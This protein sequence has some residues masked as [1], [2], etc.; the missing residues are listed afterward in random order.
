MYNVYRLP[1]SITVEYIFV[2]TKY[3]QGVVYCHFTVAKTLRLH[4]DLN[5]PCIVLHYIVKYD[6]AT[7]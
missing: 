4:L 3:F 5:I 1:Y 7:F 6:V 2:H